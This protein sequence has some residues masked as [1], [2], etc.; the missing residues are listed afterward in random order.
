MTEQ[1]KNV[2]EFLTLTMWLEKTA[3]TTESPED[4]FTFATLLSLTASTARLKDRCTAS[5]DEYARDLTKAQIERCKREVA[6]CVGTT[7]LPIQMCSKG[8]LVQIFAVDANTASDIVL[9]GACASPAAYDLVRG[10]AAFI[11]LKAVGHRLTEQA[12][13]M[14][15]DAIEARVNSGIARGPLGARH[16]ARFEAANALPTRRRGVALAEL[17]CEMDRDYDEAIEMLDKA[18]ELELAMRTATALR[19]PACSHTRASAHLN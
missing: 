13:H 10:L 18:V 2:S 3:A 14:Y 16:A 19:S 17:Q 5:L 11:M 15:F 8:H 6:R 7:S 1:A 9:Q 4:A 12:W